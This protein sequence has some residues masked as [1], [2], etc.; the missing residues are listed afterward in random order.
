ME[1]LLEDNEIGEVDEIIYPD[2]YDCCN[3]CKVC[4]TW[5]AVWMFGFGFGFL[6]KT[7]FDESCIESCDGSQ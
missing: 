4:M 2:N 7:Y 6:T 1:P 5:V 3:K